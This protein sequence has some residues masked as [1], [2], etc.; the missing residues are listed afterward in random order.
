MKKT[1]SGKRIASKPNF[2]LK[3]LHKQVITNSHY[4]AILGINC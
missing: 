2:F 1:E 4:K 3:L